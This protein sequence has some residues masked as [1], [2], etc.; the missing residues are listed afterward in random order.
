MTALDESTRQQI[1]AAK[2]KSYNEQ[3]YTY[4]SFAGTDIVAIITIPGVTGAEAIEIGSLQTITYSTH[5]ETVAAR[6]LGRIGA[7]GFTRG[8][9]T[10][11]GS[12]IFTVFDKNIVRKF[13]EQIFKNTTENTDV[14]GNS[15]IRKG[16][17]ELGNILGRQRHNVLMNGS[18]HMDEMPPF[19]VTITFGNEYGHASY[20]V[21]KGIVIIDEG[22]VM[23]IEDMLTENTYSFMAADVQVL[24]E[25]GYLGAGGN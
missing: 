1:I 7:K 20:M 19:D 21:I 14:E 10:V 17:L 11:A 24:N 2:Q 5:R 9:R 25:I 16:A 23:S 15:W 8:P 4:T 12:L 6:T 18:V 13:V 22:Q 3:G